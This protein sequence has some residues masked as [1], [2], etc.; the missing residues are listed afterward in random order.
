[1]L[2]TLLLASSAS[3]LSATS[4]QKRLDRAVLDVDLSV[5]QRVRNLQRATT[6]LRHEE[7][8]IEDALLFATEAHAGQKR[9]SGE[10]FIIHP[11]ETA[12]ILAELR[13]DCDTVVAGLLWGFRSP[14]TPPGEKEVPC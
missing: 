1:M 12:C 8:T 13:M 6:Y 11:I 5:E 4:W 7:A 3:A 9:K 14:T 2:A 10:P